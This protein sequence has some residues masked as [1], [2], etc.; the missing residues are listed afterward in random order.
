[1]KTQDLFE[2]QEML[3][4]EQFKWCKAYIDAFSI[5]ADSE[6]FTRDGKIE[7]TR[8][9]IF[10]SNYFQDEEPLPDYIRFGKIRIISFADCQLENFDMVP[11]SAQTVTFKDG[12]D[13]LS[14]SLKGL[15]K[16]LKECKRLEFPRSV[17]KG[18]LEVFKIDGMKEVIFNGNK[19]G[20]VKSKIEM[21]L[22]IV[23]EHLKNGQDIFDCQEALIAAK[24]G[25]F[26]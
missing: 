25:A 26:C 6:F 11:T 7:T 19:N 24:L 16:T 1:M 17:K 12:T 5:R 22:A 23:N 20:S 9:F 21:A 14:G 3:T 10:I 4:P 2:T 8:N 13:I 18:L 15:A